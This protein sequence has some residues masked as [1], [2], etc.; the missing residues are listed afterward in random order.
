MLTFARGITFSQL[1]ITQ[2]SGATL[3]RLVSTGEILASL[4]GGRP[5]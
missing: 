1:A 2:N 5:L 4:N 3:I